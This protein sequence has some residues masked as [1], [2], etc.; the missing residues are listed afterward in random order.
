MLQNITEGACGAVRLQSPDFAMRDETMARKFPPLELVVSCASRVP[1]ET[2]FYHRITC[3]FSP[4]ATDGNVRCQPL[5][6]ALGWR[7]LQS[8]R[9]PVT[10]AIGLGPTNEE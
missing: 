5:V 3:V 9:Y 8:S 4:R 2:L 7:E 6:I 1:R 10:S